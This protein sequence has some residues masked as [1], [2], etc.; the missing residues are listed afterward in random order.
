[1]TPPAQEFSGRSV[2]EAIA[3]GLQTLRLR[4]NQVEVQVI[5]K[6]SRGL[7]GI[8]G[9]LAVVR[10][11]PLADT[12]DVVQSPTPLPSSGQKDAPLTQTGKAAIVDVSIPEQAATIVEQTA[13]SAA[14]EATSEGKAAEATAEIAPAPTSF[15]STSSSAHPKPSDTK[16]TPPKIS[17]EAS[18]E[19]LNPEQ[20][21]VEQAAR[22]LLSRMVQ[23]MGIDAQLEI[24]WEA[25]SEDEA[26]EGETLYL[27]ITGD[28]VAQ[29]IGRH[30]DT[31]DSIQYLLRMM[32]NQRMHR[33]ANIT[34]DADHYRKRRSEQLLRLAQ[35]MA[36]QVISSQRAISLEPMPAN[37]RRLI[38]MALRDHPQVYTQS[39]GEGERRKVFIVPKRD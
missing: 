26:D 9:E 22:E 8:G 1:M 35:R 23:L 17:G 36:D 33:W 31:L 4:S 14:P 19:R 24:S 25:P 13:P 12:T 11:T 18:A 32:L 3:T 20:H 34:V 30:G 10:L 15:S 16:V 29:L 39:S 38:H 28:D 37:E 5:R 2:D 7:F 27:N 6:G 21:A